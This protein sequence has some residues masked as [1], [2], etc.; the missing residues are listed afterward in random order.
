MVHHQTPISAA[1]DAAEDDSSDP[2]PRFEQRM[3]CVVEHVYA[4]LDEPLA[5]LT[6]ADISHLSPHHWHRMY[7]AL[8]GETMAASVK[9]LRLHRAA[10]WLARE[11]GPASRADR[12][13]V[14]LPESAIVHAPVQGRIRP[15]AGTLPGGRAAHRVCRPE[16]RRTRRGARGSD[17][18]PAG[19]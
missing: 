7:H 6:L 10:G 3:R 17:S 12:A 1:A 8:Y 19:G 5:L 4:H 18:C 14:G 15:A 13:P 9:R 16:P 2:W 11:L